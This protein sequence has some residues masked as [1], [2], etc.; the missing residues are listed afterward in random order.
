MSQLPRMSAA[1]RSSYNN[2]NNNNLSDGFGNL[3]L[4]P[5][6]R[7][8]MASAR[9]TLA[10]NGRRSS[11]SYGVSTG[12]IVIAKEPRPIREKQW[13]ANSIRTLINFL[14][15]AGFNLP[16]SP[17]TL[18]APSAKDFAAIFKFLY[19]QLDPHYVFV[20]KFEEEVPVIL[21]GLRYPFSDQISKSH[22]HSVGSMHAWPTLLAMLIWIVEL[23]MLCDQM[24]KQAD[25]DDQDENAQSEKLFFEYLTKSYVVFL[26][27]GDGDEMD[28]QLATDFDRKN[29]KIFK[30][31]EKLQAEHDVLNKEW[32]SLRESESP[33]TLAERESSTLQSDIE[34]FKQYI[35]H[36]ELKKQKLG[37]QVK[38]VDDELAMK[39]S[40]LEKQSAEKAELTRIVDAQAISPA[41]V[42][43][44]TSERE[45]LV[46]TL[47]TLAKKADETNKTFWEKEI[48][49][50]KKM[51]Q[52]EK[53]VQAFNTLAYDLGFLISD[54]KDT[55]GVN[56]ELDV[57]FTAIKAE[58]M[59]S[60]DLQGKI[61][62]ILLRIRSK[63]NTSAHAFEDEAIAAQEY[64]DRLNEALAEKC[65]EVMMLEQ[66]ISKMNEKFNVEKEAYAKAN[67]ASVKEKE[68]LEYEIQ[69]MKLD[70]ATVLADSQQ[71]LQKTSLE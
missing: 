34:K 48:V 55:E 32:T 15:Q 11:I 6:A 3:Q 41:D 30:E 26:E 27:G 58:D 21:R 8:S 2:N 43:R 4:G 25:F 12:P 53:H 64:L 23:I 40:E 50:Q 65:D 14:V 56:F 54:S 57:S 35:S 9:A 33:L 63:Y 67:A 59:V 49:V 46:R 44:M 20:K 52:I 68:V 66:K 37:D 61:K 10:A 39:D 7:F 38:V 71:R 31:V 45:Q 62:P 36:L 13:Q 69:R 5:D 42:D 28:K 70:M 16:V 29:E 22:L 51:D 60:A 24:D 19:A 47:E 18:Q 17:K 1:A